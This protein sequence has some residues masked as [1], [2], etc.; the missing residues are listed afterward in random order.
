MVTGTTP[1]AIEKF[2]GEAA[3]GQQ[4]QSLR[5]QLPVQT[6]QN[7][8]DIFSPCLVDLLTNLF[9]PDPNLRLGSAPMGSRQMQNHEFFAGI[10]WYTLGESPPP[11]VPHGSRAAKLSAEAITYGECQAKAWVQL[12]LLLS[13]FTLTSYISPQW[14]LSTSGWMQTPCWAVLL[15]YLFTAPTTTLARIPCLR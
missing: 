11:F 4:M 10:N 12:G 9:E 14:N 15:W 7:L 6:R 1:F 8:A 13:Q 3:L 5:S 2:D